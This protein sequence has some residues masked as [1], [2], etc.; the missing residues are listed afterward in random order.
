M[1][2]LEVRHAASEERAVPVNNDLTELVHHLVPVSVIIIP[3]RRPVVLAQD[4]SIIRVLES[5]ESL[6]TMI[7]QEKSLTYQ[8][9]SLTLRSTEHFSGDRVLYHCVALKSVS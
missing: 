9:V 2:Q 3:H 1:I 4:P 6:S 7:S 5:N 8:G